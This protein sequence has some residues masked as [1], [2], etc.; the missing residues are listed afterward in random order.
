MEPG[1]TVRLAFKAK[2]FKTGVFNMHHC[3]ILASSASGDVNSS[4][5]LQKPGAPCLVVVRNAADPETN[6]KTRL[7]E[8]LFGLFDY[9]SEQR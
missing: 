2:V 6:S 3:R 4:S 7:E 8:D 5:V 9:K 1:E